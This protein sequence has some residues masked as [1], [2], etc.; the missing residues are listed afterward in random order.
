MTAPANTF[1]EAVALLAN[2][3]NPMSLG[4]HLSVF[5]A[6]FLDAANRIANLE[7]IT[8]ENKFRLD[9]IETRVAALGTTVAAVEQQHTQY[10]SRMTKVEE[11]PDV[12][13]K[14]IDKLDTRVRAVE[15][16]VGSANIKD[17]PVEVVPVTNG[18][19]TDKLTIAQ[20]MGFA[21]KTV[22]EQVAP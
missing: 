10:K 20:T 3:P 9:A 15:G 11:A 2:K 18:A 8:L 7:Q 13:G 17:K 5:Y 1:E 21:P 22:S 4:P 14:R 16:A 12:N 19:A 6:G